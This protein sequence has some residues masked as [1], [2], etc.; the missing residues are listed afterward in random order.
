MLEKLM[1]ADAQIPIDCNCLYEESQNL[2]NSVY[3]QTF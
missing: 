1:F 3:S 2:Q